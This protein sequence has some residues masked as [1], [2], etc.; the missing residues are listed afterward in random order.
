[1]R[2]LWFCEETTHIA[3]K[4][5][6]KQPLPLLCYSH[7][8][9]GNA[10]LGEG[11]FQRCST[12]A[13]G[14]RSREKRSRGDRASEACYFAEASLDSPDKYVASS[15]VVSSQVVSGDLVT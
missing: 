14:E 2:F 7:G 8:F 9:G 5:S 10:D 4:K 1:M 3:K 6:E 11:S 15:Q 13:E 12:P